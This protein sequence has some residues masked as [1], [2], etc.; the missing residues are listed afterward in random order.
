MQGI[1][2][3]DQGERIAREEIF[4]ECYAHDFSTIDSSLYY[5]MV[6]SIPWKLFL[7]DPHGKPG[8]SPELYNLE[9]DPHERENQAGDHPEIVEEMKGKIDAWWKNGF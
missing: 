7:P 1:D 5:R 6:I 4:A 2:V 8:K 9:R 3:L